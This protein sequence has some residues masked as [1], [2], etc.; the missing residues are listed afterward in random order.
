M[1]VT[2]SSSELVFFYD[3]LSRRIVYANEPVEHFFGFPLSLQEGFPFYP[4]SINAGNEMELE[5]QKCLTLG[6]MQAH[7]FNYTVKESGGVN[8]SYFF[9]ASG[10]NMKPIEGSFLLLCIVKRKP[11]AKL[12]DPGLRKAELYPLMEKVEL[13]D[14][15]AHDLDAPL[16]KLGVLIEM[17]TGSEELLP[18]KKLEYSNRISKC[19]GE[20]RSLI[21]SLATLSKIGTDARKLQTVNLDAT[22]EKLIR[23]FGKELGIGNSDIIVGVLGSVEGDSEE[24]QMLLKELLRNALIY[25][26]G[27]NKPV[28]RIFREAI[29]PDEQ[30]RFGL[31]EG[32][33]Y[34]K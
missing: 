21:D 6:N 31:S 32:E 17:L 18:S 24:L 22:C 23:E 8:T 29:N 1:E 19:L 2:D 30:D 14:L 25:R 26:A 5:W 34:V 11:Q 4:N 9:N 16:R 33:E 3:T 13:I 12:E 10:I 15:A 20:M 27:V 28:V 7:S